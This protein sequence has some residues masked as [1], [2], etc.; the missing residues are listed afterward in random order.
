[1]RILSISVFL[2]GIST[3]V[4]GIDLYLVSNEIQISRDHEK[5]LAVENQFR[6]YEISVLTQTI[7]KDKK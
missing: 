1:M 4:T 3:V 2:L 6:E 5:R 7:L